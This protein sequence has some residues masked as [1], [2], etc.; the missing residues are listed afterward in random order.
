MSCTSTHGTICSLKIPGCLP[1]FKWQPNY[2]QNETCLKTSESYHGYAKPSESED[3][4]DRFYQSFWTGEQYC[5]AFGSRLATPVTYYDFTNITS[6]AS[7]LERK[8][9]NGALFVSIGKCKNLA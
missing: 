7:S 5:N 9:Y 1:G 8:Y 3:K 6:F 4:P 2:K